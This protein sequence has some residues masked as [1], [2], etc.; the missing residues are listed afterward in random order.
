MVKARRVTDILGGLKITCLPT[1]LQEHEY[2]KS[3]YDA[4]KQQLLESL[5]IT[6]RARHQM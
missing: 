2:G 5:S 3:Y 6:V 4:Y 1:R